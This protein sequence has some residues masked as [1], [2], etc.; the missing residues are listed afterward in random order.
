MNSASSMHGKEQ[1]CIQDFGMKARNTSLE[2]SGWRLWDN[3]KM[4]H[5][6]MRHGL[7]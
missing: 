1:K 3:V 6:G 5:R 2:R 7:D 4:H